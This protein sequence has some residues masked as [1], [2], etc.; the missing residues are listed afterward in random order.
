MAEIAKKITTILGLFGIIFSVFF[1]F[2]RTYAHNSALQQLASK[3][4]DTD[5]G[6]KII[7]LES[8]LEKKRAQLAEARKTGNAE[9]VESIENDIDDIKRRISMLEE[10]AL[11]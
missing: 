4:D 11:N 10:K 5:L 6:L 3:V 2:E 1:F 8:I 9:L 7:T